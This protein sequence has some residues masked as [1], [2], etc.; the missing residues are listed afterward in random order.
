MGRKVHPLG[1]RLGRTR[2]WDS[3]WYADFTTLATMRAELLG[4]KAS[5]AKA[6]S[7]SLPLMAPQ[8]SRALRGATCRNFAFAQTSTCYSPIVPVR[9]LN[10]IMANAHRGRRRPGRRSDPGT[11]SWERTR[12]ACDPPCSPLCKPARGGGRRERRSCV[13]PFRGKLSSAGSRCAVRLCLRDGP[14]RGS[15]SKA[16]GPRRVLF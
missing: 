15:S 16:A 8:T 13:P 6:V 3:Q 10:S 1:Y 9:P 11:L 14:S 5:T 4:R 12:R 7:M 2:N